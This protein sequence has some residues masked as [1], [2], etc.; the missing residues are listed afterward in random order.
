MIAVIFKATLNQHLLTDSS[1]S[2][3]NQ[4]ELNRYLK[5]ADV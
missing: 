4:E 5:M 1:L 3:Q 2:S